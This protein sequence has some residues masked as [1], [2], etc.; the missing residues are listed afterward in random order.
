MRNILCIVTISIIGFCSCDLSTPPP[1][2]A[3]VVVSPPPSPSLERARQ[4]KRVEQV[5]DSLGLKLPLISPPLA[6][7]VDVTQSRN[8]LYLAGK[9]PKTASGEYVKGKLGRELSVEQGYDAARRVGVMQLAVLKN[10]LGDLGKVKRILKVTGMVNATPDFTQHP[11]VV[12]GFSD[13]MV[14]VFGDAGKHA[15]AAVG[16]AS[17]PRNICVEIDMVVEVR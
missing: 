3:P 16:M 14:E 4:A 11:E 9:G 1:I 2:Q 8:I 13:L 17:L 12:N 10:H 6:N 7:Y 5:L 15:R